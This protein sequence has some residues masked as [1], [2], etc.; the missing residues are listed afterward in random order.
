MVPGSIDGRYTLG[1][2]GRAWLADGKRGD[3]PTLQ[4]VDG[5]P[6]SFP[7]QESLIHNWTRQNMFSQ[8]SAAS[9][10]RS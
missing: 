1:K 7:W 5:I 9:M 6:P 2:G 3:H 10:L 8:F 4:Q